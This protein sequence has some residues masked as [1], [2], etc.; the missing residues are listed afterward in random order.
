M[1]Y[2]RRIKD[3]SVTHIWN[4]DQFPSG[5]K[6]SEP[7]WGRADSYVIEDC[8][9]EMIAEK[10]KLAD[11]QSKKSAAVEFLKSTSAGKYDIGQAVEAIIS[12]MGLR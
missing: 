5:I 4:D 9:A 11:L 7:D 2:Y 12:L 3:K 1:N 6:R 10:S 8:T